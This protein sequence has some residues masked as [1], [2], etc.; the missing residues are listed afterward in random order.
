MTLCSS[1]LPSIHLSIYFILTANLH[2][3]IFRHRHCCS[4]HPSQRSR[5]HLF[6]SQSRT[7]SNVL[8]NPHPH[9]PKPRPPLCSR[10]LA[11]LQLELRL[12]FRLAVRQ[13][14]WERKGQ[15]QREGDRRVGG[16]AAEEA[17]LAR[18]VTGKLWKRRD[19]DW[20]ADVL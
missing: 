5:A 19:R 10:L 20:V 15:R 1:Y 4:S 8:L 12:V 11:Q 3:A 16:A 17:E 18:Y 9:R 13:S 7:P 2:C 6:L 14:C